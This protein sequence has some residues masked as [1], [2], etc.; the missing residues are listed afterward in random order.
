MRIALTV[1]FFF[2][3][4]AFGQVSLTTPG[5]AYTQNF[6]TLASTGASSTVPT[7]WAFLESGTSSANNGL[8][9]AG[10][11]SGTAGD[12]YSFGLA[13][14]TDRAFGGL[15]SNT[16]TPT[17]GASFTNN[18]GSTITQ[19]TIAYTGE[20]WRLGALNREDRLEFQ[21]SLDATSLST[22]TWVGVSELNFVAPTQSPT[23]GAL[24]GND[25]ANRRLISHTITGLNIPAGA[26][27]WIRWNDFNASGADDG[28]AIDD[29]SLTPTTGSAPLITLSPESLP[30]LTVGSPVTV[31]FTVNNATGCTLGVSA[32]SLPQGLTLSGATLSG[33]PQASGAYDFTIAATGCSGGGAA[34]RQY[35]GSIAGA[36]VNACGAPA[37]LIS[38]IQGSGSTSPLVGQTVTVEAIVNGAFLGSSALNGFYLQEEPA[39]QDANPATSEG[40]FVFYPS[41]AVPLA[42]GDRVRVQGTVAEFTSGSA[43][44][45]QL[46]SVT[47]V[48]V[49][50]AGNTVSPVDISLPVT[51]LSDL[52]SYEGM[53]VRFPQTL[54]VTDNF[55]HGRFGELVL[56]TERQTQFTQA[57]LPSIA[58]NAAYQDIIARS[59][60]VLD[61]GNGAQNRDP[62]YHPASG[63]SAA[64]TVRGGAQVSGLTGVLDHRFSLYRIQPLAPVNF[65]GAPRPA[66]AP[67]LGGRFKVG[68]L[69]VLNFFNGNGIGGGFPTS[70][71]ADSPAELERQAAKLV[72]ALNKLDAAVVGLSELEN[73][74]DG[75]GSAIEELVTRANAAAGYTKWAPIFTGV[76]GTD[77]IRNGILYQPALVTPVGNFKFLDSTI[78]PD[79]HFTNRPALAQQFQPA[80]SPVKPELQ[81]FFVVVNH[82]KSKGSSSGQPGDADA[83]DGQ[84]LSNGTR[85]RAAQALARWLKSP[86]FDATPAASRKIIIVGDLNSYL[87][88]DPIT[89][90]VTEGFP[91]LI[92]AIGAGPAEYSYSF[93]GQWG[94][95][96]H[97]LVSQNLL[98]LVSGF[99]DWHI[100]ADEPVVIDYNVNFKTSNQITLFYAPDE[101][102]S[103]DHD[104]LVLGFNPLC[105]DLDD[106]GDVDA[107]DQLLMRNAI[108]KQGILFDRRYDFDGSGGKDRT[109][110]ISLNDWRLWSACAAAYQR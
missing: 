16:L 103:S 73:D 17:I 59:R 39:D 86:G 33:A 48:Q 61:D 82:F 81:R 108:G 83:G 23:I 52:E 74:P 70:R 32:G 49:C 67:V 75:P 24:N 10:N 25:A 87:R 29:F 98:T 72:A 53:L 30:T 95:L 27:F 101:F 77:E 85:T 45:T 57:N 38:S 68:F 2:V 34:S 78:D 18:T 19:L 105:G 3:S 96:D 90:L 21:Y 40:L 15:L 7:G 44:L 109:G 58:G 69:N 6:D 60:I 55:T 36:Q 84:G 35:T 62:I 4:L 76:L 94:N 42:A 5:A 20:Q 93:G 46:T 92:D 63:F 102:R 66:T 11:G 8:Y 71:G 80:G 56:A 12:T 50:G 79:F 41:G 89:A 65:T 47:S 28:L 88:E 37:T 26:T 91:N 31:A 9:T 13:G 51:S 14:N 97:A 107:A 1:S 54:T 100:N 43:S 106:D 22:G 110:T 99:G 104:P 64:N